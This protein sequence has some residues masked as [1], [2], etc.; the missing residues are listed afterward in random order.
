[1]SQFV[2]FASAQPAISVTAMRGQTPPVPAGGYG[3]W[4]VTDRPKRKGLPTWQGIDP[5]RV[6]VPIIIGIN[7]L[8]DC[9]VRNVSAEPD[10][11]ALERLAQPPA[12]GQEPPIVT[13]TGAVPHANVAW[14]I[15]DF[16]WDTDPI[17]SASG[18]IVRQ[19]VTVHLLEHVIDDAIGYPKPKV[20]AKN[21]LYTVAAGD[22]LTKIAG[23]QLA[24]ASRHF[25][26][27]TLNGIRDGNRL[28]IG[29]LLRMP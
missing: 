12:V 8:G 6:L 24:D 16:D 18:F 22:T 25:E 2:T 7:K 26:L 1:M 11:T 3:G 27:A 4:T 29:Q 17:Y 5:R 28:T 20:T 23:R 19:A 21:K 14:V 10:R 15:E 13:V 9:L